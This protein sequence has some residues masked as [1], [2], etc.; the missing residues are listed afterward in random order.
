M[1]QEPKLPVRP[2]FHLTFHIVQ[3]SRIQ[4]ANQEVKLRTSAESSGN[5]GGHET[6]FLRLLRVGGVSS[7][8]ARRVLLAHREN[9]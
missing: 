2:P 5:P 9:V 6:Q 8:K 4:G 7:L 1:R 3:Q